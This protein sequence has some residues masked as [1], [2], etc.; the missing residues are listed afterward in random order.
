MAETQVSGS[1]WVN[2]ADEIKIFF[3]LYYVEGLI[4]CNLVDVYIYNPYKCI[5]VIRCY[6]LPREKDILYNCSHIYKSLDMHDR[7]SREKNKK[8]IPQ[9]RFLRV[10]A[11]PVSP[12]NSKLKHRRSLSFSPVNLIVEVSP[13]YNI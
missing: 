9:P 11:C 1:H 10:N 6:H 2:R 4:W 3:L 8:P 7:N 13:S 12:Q 5:F